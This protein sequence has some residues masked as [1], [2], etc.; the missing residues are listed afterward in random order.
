MA[1]CHVEA[2]GSMG[3]RRGNRAGNAVPVVFGKIDVLIP[4][5]SCIAGLDGRPG[6][7]DVEKRCHDLKAIGAK[8]V[9]CEE[10]KVSQGWRRESIG[11]SFGLVGNDPSWS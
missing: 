9:H 7:L 1:G 11:L 2:A 8:M 4:H 5:K 3:K 6:V 10:E